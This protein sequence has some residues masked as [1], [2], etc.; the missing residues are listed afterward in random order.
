MLSFR[1]SIHI[2]NDSQ[3]NVDF[4]SFPTRR[5]SD[6]GRGF[7]LGVKMICTRSEYRRIWLGAILWPS[8]MGAIAL[9]FIVF[10]L[11]DPAE[12]MFLGYLQLS[13]AAAYTLGF[14][15]FWFVGI[16]ISYLTIKITP[17]KY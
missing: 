12:V 9:C 14:F 8:F 4:H 1:Q 2:M 16:V 17:P 5:S 3:F 13:R 15:L 11:V 7:V 6:L 10:M